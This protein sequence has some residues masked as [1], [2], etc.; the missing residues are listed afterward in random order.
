MGKE[1]GQN[2]RQFGPYITLKVLAYGEQTAVYSAIHETTGKTVA[3]RILTISARDVD[4]ATEECM[5][6]LSDISGIEIANAPKMLDFGYDGAILYIAMDIL[7]GGTLE[8]RM[9]R[10]MEDTEKVTLPSPTDVLHMTERM[11]IAID[12]MHSLNIIHGQILPHSIMFDNQ[13]NAYLIEIGITRILKIIYNLEATNSFN[14]TRYSAPELWNGERPGPWTDQ[15][16][17]ACIV[18]QLITGKAPF[19]EPSIFSLMNAHANDV[20]APPH[21]VRKGLPSD[22][23]MIF[24][25]A[26]AKPTDRRYPT[27]KA[28]YQDLQRAF[29]DDASARTDFFTFPLD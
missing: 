10:R 23:A 24:W 6:V 18:Y 1:S 9:K 17:L 25:Q 12:A 14:M 26:L 11:A 28:F 13:G 2:Q 7:H 4:T 8:E 22:L 5:Q 29:S 20:A 21:Y 15:Y 3:L 19:D 16:A 27:I